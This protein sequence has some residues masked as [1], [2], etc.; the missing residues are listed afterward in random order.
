MKKAIVFNR[1]ETYLT[2]EG[3]K[4]C[5]SFLKLFRT[6]ELKEKISE[7]TFLENLVSKRINEVASKGFN[8]E[9][10]AI[11]QHDMY[12]GQEFQNSDSHGVIGF[13]H[14]GKDVTYK[15]YFGPIVEVDLKS[16]GCKVPGCKLKVPGCKLKGPGCKQKVPGC[17]SKGGDGVQHLNF[18][19][20]K[21][22]IKEVQQLN[23]YFKLR[24]KYDQ[25]TQDFVYDEVTFDGSTVPIEVKEYREKIV[26]EITKDLKAIHGEGYG[27][28]KTMEMPSNDNVFSHAMLFSNNSNTHIDTKALA[29]PI[30]KLKNKIYLSAFDIYYFAKV[31]GLLSKLINLI[32][33]FLRIISFGLLFS[34]KDKE[35][36]QEKISGTSVLEEENIARLEK[37][38]TEDLNSQDANQPSKEE[39]NNLVNLAKEYYLG[40]IP[41][42]LAVRV[43]RGFIFTKFYEFLFG[44]KYIFHTYMIDAFKE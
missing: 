18:F 15:T 25:E 24:L 6:D 23:N 4:G 40:K 7:K 22:N 13:E 33:I 34:D 14:T 27:F 16:L 35:K 31:E 9:N 8:Y 20:D 10:D 17:T 44:R 29:T 41:V 32:K 12:I 37:I 1:M 19:N 30:A 3:C 26:K 43:D 5:K 21:K 39:V 42:T 28:E 38:Y 2:K 36:D 11:Y